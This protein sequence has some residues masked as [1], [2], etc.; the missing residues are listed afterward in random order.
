MFFWFISLSF[1]FNNAG[2]CVCIYIYIYIYK[3]VFVADRAVT[4]A[5]VA[6]TVTIVIILCYHLIL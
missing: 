1:C 2:V 6:T 4:A 5:R 3:A